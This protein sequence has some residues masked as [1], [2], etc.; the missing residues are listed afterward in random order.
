MGCNAVEIFSG[1]RSLNTEKR[2]LSFSAELDDPSVWLT[3]CRLDSTRFA[4]AFC[5]NESKGWDSYLIRIFTETNE[6]FRFVQL[7]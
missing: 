7:L 3:L 6:T 1:C 2:T 4:S 5:C